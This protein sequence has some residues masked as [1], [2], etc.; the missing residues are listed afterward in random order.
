MEKKFDVI[1]SGC[2]PSGSLLGSLLAQQNINTLILEKELFPREKTCG[3]GLRHRA[4][5]LLPFNA[6]EA[7]EKTIYGIYF[8]L[9]NNDIILKRYEEPLVYTVVRSAFDSLLSTYAIKK[10]CTINF[11]EKIT[12]FKVFKNFIT[13]KTDKNTYSAKIL[14]GADGSRGIVHKNLNRAKKVNRILGYETNLQIKPSVHNVE[15]ISDSRGFNFNL[16]D[17]IRLDF[18]GTKKGYCWVFPKKESISCG[19]GAPFSEAV[20]IRDYLRRFISEFYFSSNPNAGHL[21]ISAHGIPVSNGSNPVCNYRLVALGDAAC[22]GDGF[23]GEGLYNCFKSSVIASECIKDSL[24][25]SNF[26][27]LNYAERIEAEILSDIRA[28]LLF[29]S[30]FY[31]SINLFYRLIIRDEKI[32]SAC[33]KILRGEKTYKNIAARL[34][35]YRFSK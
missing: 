27:F 34:N 20:K 14:A 31:R 26:T 9:R 25:N 5:K 28:S 10:G 12:D 15:S 32:F 21:K 1:I 13:V 2:G 17:N 3:G 16:S 19:I 22:L 8:S 35:F 29:T 23:T 6:S 30:V 24:K 7:I 18:R 4:L 33:C 11:G